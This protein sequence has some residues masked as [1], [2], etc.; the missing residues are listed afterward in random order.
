MNSISIYLINE[1]RI[2]CFRRDKTSERHVDCVHAPWEQN[3]YQQLIN[4]S[5]IVMR[6]VASV[7]VC[8]I[9][10]CDAYDVKVHTHFDDFDQKNRLKLGFRFFCGFF[11]FSVSIAFSHVNEMPQ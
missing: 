5:N 7:I 3:I 2:F 8:G 10:K 1:N 6:V 9:L 11:S 4:S